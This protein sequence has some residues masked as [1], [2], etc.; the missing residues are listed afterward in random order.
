M[1]KY[2]YP[3]VVFRVSLTDP[4]GAAVPGAKITITNKEQGITQALVSSGAG[5]FTTGALAPGAYVVKV[6][7]PNFKTF[8]TVAT[9]QIG[10]MV[11][12]NA[13]LELGTPSTLVEV[14]ETTLAI[15]SEQSSVQDVLTAKIS[16]NCR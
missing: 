7:A 12:A 15:N 4:Q 11:S 14:S 16:T 1:R 5:Y 3:R 13:R 6:E 10:Q 2:R 9:V 8:Q